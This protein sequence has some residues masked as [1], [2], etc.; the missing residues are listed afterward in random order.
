MRLFVAVSVG[1]Q[2][3]D[4]A[5]RARSRIE[6]GLGK[7]RGEPPRIVWVSAQ[8]LHLTLRFLGEQPDERVPA[9]VAAIREP[10]PIPPF[11]VTWQGLGAFP[12]PRHPRAIWVGVTDGARELG[13]LERE[14]SGRVGSLLPGE[15]ATEAK[16]FH[17]HLTL[18]RVKTDSN[19]V[20][21]PAILADAAVTGVASPITHV[22]LYRSRGLP[23]GAGY[24][25]LCRGHL[26]GG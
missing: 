3:R 17:P 1:D 26:T 11:T 2:V 22:T 18:A 4:A 8:G 12:S 7:L 21:W 5:A 20:N 13:V 14:I 24:E 15:D 19:R 23:G 16:P 25:E 10:L 6:A 9:M